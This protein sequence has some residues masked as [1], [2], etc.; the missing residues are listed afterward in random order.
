MVEKCRVC[1][2]ECDKELVCFNTNT[3][4]SDKC[5]TEYIEI[6][7]K[8]KEAKQSKADALIEEALKKI[9]GGE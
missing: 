7:T 3:F 6:Q 5:C 2:E 4:C 1:K 8:K 9:E